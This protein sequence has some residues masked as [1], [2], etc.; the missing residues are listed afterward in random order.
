M[1][2]L[3]SPPNALREVLLPLLYYNEEIKTEDLLQVTQLKALMVNLVL[4]SVFLFF[5]NNFIYFRLC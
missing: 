3:N 4:D 5:F 1:Y 2:S